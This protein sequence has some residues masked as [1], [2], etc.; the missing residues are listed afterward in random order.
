MRASTNPGRVQFLQS[1]SRAACRVAYGGGGLCTPHTANVCVFACTYFLQT[2]DISATHPSRAS[3]TCPWSFSTWVP[4]GSGGGGEKTG[5]C[6]CHIPDWL[7]GYRAVYLFGCV[8]GLRHFKIFGRST[9][10]LT[11]SYRSKIE[12]FESVAAP[13]VADRWKPPPRRHSFECGVGATATSR[14]V[15]HF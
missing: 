15:T 9:S 5:I 7:R 14:V 2:C 11:R 10:T 12:Y 1:E 4:L 3:G 8:V 13:L 6:S